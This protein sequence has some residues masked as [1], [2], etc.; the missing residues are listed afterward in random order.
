MSGSSLR[1]ETKVRDRSKSLSD[2]EDAV[3]EVLGIILVLTITVVLFTTV[4]A[5]VTQLDPPEERDHADLDADF[6]RTDD[7]AYVNI[8]HQ[9]GE[10]LDMEDLTFILITDNNTYTYEEG[11]VLLEG[12]DPWSAGESVVIEETRGDLRLSSTV[13]LVIRNKDTNR[14]IYDTTLVEQEDAAISIQSANIY[15]LYEWRDYAEPEEEIEIRA[16][17]ELGDD[18]DV[19]QIQASVARGNV[20]EEGA[21]V[22]LTKLRGNI[23]NK[24]L[25]ISSDAEIR[26]HSVKITAETLTGATDEEY[27]SLNV[28]AESASL[29]QAD[30]VVGE[31]RFVPRS[32]SHGDDLT[33]IADIYNNGQVNYTAEWDIKDD[34]EVVGEGETTFGHGPAPTEI[35]ATFEVEGH[36]PH[37]I[38]ANVSTE[39]QVEGEDEIE[40][41]VQPE[42]NWRKVTLH[43]DPHVM[44]VRDSLGEELREGRIME[45]ALR[46]LNLDYN[47]RDISSKDDIPS[48]DEFRSELNE[49]SVVIWMSGNRSGEVNLGEPDASEAVEE[50]IVED[51]GVFWLIGS[52]LKD[53][54]FGTLEDKLGYNDFS[55]KDLNEETVLKPGGENGTYGDHNY[56]AGVGDDY[57]TMNVK[58]EDK[59]SLVD[60]DG[61]IY[62]IGYEDQEEQRTAVN[63]FLFENVMDPG[64]RF[65]MASE[66]IDWLTNMTTRTGV[67]VAVSSQNIEPTAPMYMDEVTITT[68][69]RNNGP[70][71]LY[72]TVRCVRNRGEEVLRPKEEGAIFVAKDGGTNNVTFKWT[73]EA[74]GVQEF[75]VHADYFNEIDEVN[76]R[77]NDIT[78]KDL[79]VTDDVIDINVHYSTLVVDA[80]LSDSPDYDHNATADVIDSFEQL[81][82]QKGRDYDY[83]L[84]EGARNNPEDGPDYDTMSEYNAV[85]WV[86][87]ERDEEVLTDDD[88]F[89]IERYLKS[90]SGGNVMFIGEH[91]L[92]YLDEE[93][94]DDFLGDVMGVDPFSIGQLGYEPSELIGQEDNNLSHGLKYELDGSAQLDTFDTLDADVL[95]EDEEGN[96]LA[97]I[98]DEGS[99]K[100]VYMGANLSRLNGPLVDEEKYE[101]WPGGE[102]DLGHQS[103]RE[104][105]IYTTM[106]Q[107]GKRD[108]RAELRVVDH[109]VDFALDEPHTGRS[110]EIE[111]DIQNIG[112]RGTSTLV[113]IKEGEDYI[114]SETLFVEGSERVSEDGSTYFDIEPG[115]ATLEITWRPSNAGERDIRVRV[116]PL[117]R[118]RE[119]AEDGEE[120]EENKLME[121]NNQAA[122]EQPV[123]FFYDD[124]EDD[125]G[126]WRHDS[127][128][129]NIDGTGPLDFVDR[130]DVDTKV[131]GDWDADHSGLTYNDGSAEFGE[132]YYETDEEDVEDFTDSAHYTSP[133]S[134]WMPETP[135]AGEERKP[136]DLYLVIDESGS[137][138][139]TDDDSTTRME[140]A[141]DAAKA[142]VGMLREGDRVTVYGFDSS[143]TKI[144]DRAWTNTSTDRANI[145]STIEDLEAGGGTSLFDATAAAVRDM[146]G[147]DR[148]SVMGLVTLTDGVSN[149][150]DN[151]NYLYAPGGGDGNEPDE[152]APAEYYQK[153]Q[154]SGLLGIPY[155]VFTVTIGNAPDARMHS[156]PAT[157]TADIAYG[158]YESDAAKLQGLFEM[159]IS[160][161]MK[162]SQGGL[163][164]VQDRLERDKYNNNI[165]QNTVEDTEFMVFSDGFRTKDW[166]APGYGAWSSSGFEY[167]DRELEWDGDRTCIKAD[168]NGESVSQTI[169]P[170]VMLNEMSG[171]YSIKGAYVSFLLETEEVGWWDPDQSSLNMRIDGS[172]VFTGMED[173]WGDYHKEDISSYVSGEDSFD[174]EFIHDGDPGADL[175]L[176]DVS[177]TYEL[178]YDPEEKEESDYEQAVGTDANY[179]YTTTPEIDVR[180]TASEKLRF[181]TRYS[182]TE[183]TNGGMMYLWGNNGG[184]WEWKKNSRRYIRP[185]QSYTGNLDFDEVENHSSTGGPDLTGD[186]GT[187]LI[188]REDDLPYWCFNGKS[189]SGAFDWQFVSVDLS[190]YEN[191]MGDF[192]EVRVVFVMAQMGGISP[193]SGWNEDMGWYIDNVN[194]RVTRTAEGEIPQDGNGYWMRVNKTELE[195]EKGFNIPV[196]EEDKYYD[197]TLG[198]ENGHYWLYTR[199]DNDETALPQGVD[200]SLYTSMISLD[201]AEQPE[202]IAYMKFN[203]DNTSAVPPDGLRI[204]VSEDDGRSWDSLTYGI[205]SGW[206][207]SGDT[208]HGKYSGE[209]DD[210]EYGWVNASSLARVSTDL[211]GYRGENIILRFRVF[212]NLTDSYEVDDL[213]KGIFIDDV[214]V[215]ESDMDISAVDTENPLE[216]DL[217]PMKENRVQTGFATPSLLSQNHIQFVF[218]EINKEPLGQLEIFRS[219]I[220]TSTYGLDHEVVDMKTNPVLDER[221]GKL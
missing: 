13:D 19:D 37:E 101:D 68:T 187:G 51:E 220:F 55:N 199:N 49:S 109:D 106:W 209:T 8:T 16:E 12:Q 200:S 26:R 165:I 210:G 161:L 204:E 80:D 62:G 151:D 217:G 130:E 35:T 81:G 43:V 18:E 67:D 142:A 61:N 59:N 114:G 44:I 23:Y 205:R 194:L 93:N 15:Y 99:F 56:T 17:V 153:G 184:D 126:Y 66:V 146:D 137:M 186:G 79:E 6:E 214:M 140:Y 85:F 33:V 105:L 172:D 157:S 47:V 196:G 69:L 178:D 212:T 14:I 22:N 45:N 156:I 219:N 211:S 58:G 57:L 94:E 83:Y 54:N 107:L 31:I 124:M 163:K 95:F 203:L 175:W 160:E 192:D 213:P 148:D 25:I 182:M 32:P 141:I 181:R 63:S 73:A 36:G 4:F 120:D 149:S 155:N 202:L 46:G 24:T 89:Y 131:A 71:D 150:D 207:A 221:R 100:V 20:F 96:N 7:K 38:E 136:M 123:Y 21:I 39:L 193:E 190:D 133:R 176:D 50:F 70:E 158:V 98:Y 53:E 122:V 110:Y 97:S 30:L 171:S 1:G 112:Y 11:Q 28:G 197:H 191:F 185:E 201:N 115:T 60:D 189:G 2:G 48:K 76:E 121:F 77:N 179:R 167:N 125:T 218:K 34:G 119:I 169:D 104:E 108:G 102:V 134:Y 3:S 90:V 183:G 180:D 42:D 10:S 87:G 164:S 177:V 132:G 152:P 208:E 174:L 195:D 86:T 116:D 144:V 78:Y 118:V 173:D 159:F 216:D 168:S 206:G 127:T 166:T 135:G 129:V 84:V 91:I 41:D 64:Q 52:N 5:A 138:G 198:D 40:E 113:R 74:L 75:I 103:A 117:R 29:Y 162:E 92:D 147:I 111:V 65:S 82:H 145:N 88:M 72:V 188:D 128:V 27:L 9:S 143:V 215:V 170:S 154:E 139:N